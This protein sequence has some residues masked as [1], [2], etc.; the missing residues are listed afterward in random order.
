MDY[1]SSK[2]F[3]NAEGWQWLSIYVPIMELGF[4]RGALRDIGHSVTHFHENFKKLNE[5]RLI[6]Y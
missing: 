6:K 1:L 4:G 3:E 2:F 5:K